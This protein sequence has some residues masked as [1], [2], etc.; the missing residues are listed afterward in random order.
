VT[1][2][3]MRMS[4]PPPKLRGGLEDRDTAGHLVCCRGPVDMVIVT[5][6][7]NLSGTFDNRPG[8]FLS[9]GGAVSLLVHACAPNYVSAFD[10]LYALLT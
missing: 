9:L 7:V 8:R 1:H 10:Q 6:L 3:Q 4:D 2:E 5:R